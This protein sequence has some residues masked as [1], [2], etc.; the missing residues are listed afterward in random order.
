MTGG[1]FLFNSTAFSLTRLLTGQLA[2]SMDVG[3]RIL[4]DY[5]ASRAR[6]LEL[7]FG[8]THWPIPL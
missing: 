3:S 5:P 7:G 8:K 6:F 2:A 4:R 1:C